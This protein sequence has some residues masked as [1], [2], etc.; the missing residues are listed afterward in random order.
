[1]CGIYFVEGHIHVFKETKMIISDTGIKQPQNF[2]NFGS[3]HPNLKLLKILKI[4]KN[5]V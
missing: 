2:R 1:M 4:Q 3:F 5:N